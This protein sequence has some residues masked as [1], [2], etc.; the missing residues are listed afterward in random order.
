MAALSIKPCNKIKGNPIK[1]LT[2]QE[3]RMGILIL[4]NFLWSFTWLHAQECNDVVDSFCVDKIEATVLGKVS[5][6]VSLGITTHWEL[7][8]QGRCHSGWRPPGQKLVDSIRWQGPS[9]LGDLVYAASKPSVVEWCICL[10]G[11]TLLS[12][13]TL[14]AKLFSPW[15]VLVELRAKVSCF[16]KVSP[17]SSQAA[18]KLGFITFWMW[19]DT[20]TSK[21]SS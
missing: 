3:E 21:S 16:S 2:C 6:G 9:L 19:S 1:F 18:A 14:L 5:T 8:L 13:N 17:T 7:G 12:G 10:L 15:R 4:G 11:F 20:V